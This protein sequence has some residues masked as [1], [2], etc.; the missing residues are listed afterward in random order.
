M[1]KM[2]T[3]DIEDED[4]RESRISSILS[5]LDTTSSPSKSSQPPTSFHGKER[6][7]QD[8]DASSDLLS[9]VQAF[10][11]QLEASNKALLR[12]AQE[13]PSSVDIENVEDEENYIEMNLGLGVFEDRSKA[14]TASNHES[15]SDSESSDT[16]SSSGSDSD[17]ESSGGSSIIDS[18]VSTSALGSRP[19]KPLPRRGSAHPGIVLLDN[20]RASGS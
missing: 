5:R 3:L 12:R 11:P 14:S 19:I 6:Q 9:R 1:E 8:I 4:A 18:E 10:L 20:S 15:D 2:E 17:S 13:D 7:P 16:S